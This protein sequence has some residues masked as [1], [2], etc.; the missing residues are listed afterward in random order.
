MTYADQLLFAC[1]QHIFLCEFDDSAHSALFGYRFGHGYKFSFGIYMQYRLYMQ[2]RTYKSFGF[3]YSSC[4]AEVVYVFDSEEARRFVGKIFYELYAIFVTCTAIA[5]AESVIGD[6]SFYEASSFGVN[7][8][9][10]AFGEFFSEFFRCGAELI[11]S[12][13]ELRREAY[14][15]YVVTF[16]EYRFEK[17]FCRICRDH[18]GRRQ[19]FLGLCVAARVVELFGRKFVFVAVKVFTAYAV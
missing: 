9:Y 13:A 17:L 14:V 1:G 5:G 15:Y 16:F 7:D 3:A 4:A 19:V 6:K 8:G 12:A 11:E 18:C 10:P 2:G